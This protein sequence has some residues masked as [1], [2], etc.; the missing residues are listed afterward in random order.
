MKQEESAKNAEQGLVFDE[1]R[2]KKQLVFSFSLLLIFALTYFFAAVVT[3][4]ELKQIAAIDI[5]GLPLAF[6]LGLLVFLVGVVVT[7]LYLM[8]ILKG[9]R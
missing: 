8:K 4:K 3:T 1:A 9:W 5:L 2:F 7:R 6:Y